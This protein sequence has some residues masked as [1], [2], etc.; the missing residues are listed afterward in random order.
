MNNAVIKLVS[1]CILKTSLKS[2]IVSWF[3]HK[4][5][6]KIHDVAMEG[7][8]AYIAMDYIS[9][10][11]MSLRLRKREYITVGEFI[12]ISKALLNA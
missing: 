9:G 11:S 2:K 12:L 6:V 3:E 7:N 4:N 5:I 8:T 1:L 10:H